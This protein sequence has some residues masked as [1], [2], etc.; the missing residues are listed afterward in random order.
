MKEDV[1]VAEI[2]EDLGGSFNELSGLDDVNE[3]SDSCC[4]MLSEVVINVFG[5]LDI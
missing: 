5:V 4:I 3:E 1:T 2:R